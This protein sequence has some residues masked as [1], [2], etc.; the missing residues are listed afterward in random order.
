M[1]HDFY[2]TYT[3]QRDLNE[4]HR[5]AAEQRQL[6]ELRRAR[7]AERPRAGTR[8]RAWIAS[9]WIGRPTVGRAAT[10]GEEC[11]TC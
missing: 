4:R 9:S 7:R 8:L 5:H 6:R 1:N 11:V 10:P 3:L 2:V